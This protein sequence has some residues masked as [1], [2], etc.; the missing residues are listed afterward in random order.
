MV[1]DRVAEAGIDW[2]YARLVRRAEDGDKNQVRELARIFRPEVLDACVGMACADIDSYG[3]DAFVIVRDVC[4][5][6][7]KR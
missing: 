1:D 6:L 4:R 5:E 3:G 2:A 7:A